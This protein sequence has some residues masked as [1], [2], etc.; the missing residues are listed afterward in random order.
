MSSLKNVV[1][2][3]EHKERHQPRHR[4]KFGLLEKKKDYK[5][6]ARDYQSKRE[7]V[8]ILTDNAALRNPDEFY[9]KMEKT[10]R[11]VR[12]ISQELRSGLESENN[13]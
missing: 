1:P 11:R 10:K 2:Q 4:R 9:Y 7:R 3:R 13:M 6:R 5:I 8:R 12:H